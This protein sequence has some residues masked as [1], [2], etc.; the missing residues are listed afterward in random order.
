[1]TR[2]KIWWGE[3]ISAT[4]FGQLS[5]EGSFKVLMNFTFRLFAGMMKDVVIIIR[6]HNFEIYLAT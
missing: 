3:A 5:P 4:I 6:K 2:W 1:M